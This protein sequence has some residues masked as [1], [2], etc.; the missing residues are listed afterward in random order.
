MRGKR[1]TKKML[2]EKNKY[3]VYH[4]GLSPIGKYSM[5]NRDANTVM[6]IN[7]GASAGTV[8]FC[9][10]DFWSSDG[11]FC[12]DL[13]NSIMPKYAYHALAIKQYLIQ[14]RVRKAGIPTLD[15]NAVEEIEIPIP[16][17]VEQERIVSILDK[18]EVLVNDLSQGLPAEIEARR[19]QYE[20]YRN[21][22]LTFERR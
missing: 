20:H 3:P 5:K 2:S 6:I 4:G 17:L 22:L 9:K 13:N 8:G 7:V 1:L 12:L 16:S 10:T 11:C 14:S 15:A 18:F 19:Q 21:R